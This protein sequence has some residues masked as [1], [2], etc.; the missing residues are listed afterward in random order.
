MFKTQKSDSKY[1][2]ELKAFK[3]LNIKRLSNVWLYRHLCTDSV[4]NEPLTR[5]FVCLKFSIGDGTT[6]PGT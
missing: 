2:P 4:I 6:E 3:I 5:L 1:S